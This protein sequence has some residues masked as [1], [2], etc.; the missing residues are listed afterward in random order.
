[1]I[2]PATAGDAEPRPEAG[3]SL[4]GTQV[5][6]LLGVNPDTVRRWAREGRLKSF[7]T[8]GGHRRY[9]ESQIAAILKDVR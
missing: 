4:S 7:R 5:A 3:K 1:M 9:P 8:P 6:A 2:A